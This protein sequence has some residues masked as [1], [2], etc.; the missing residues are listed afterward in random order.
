MVQAFVGTDLATVLELEEW[1]AKVGE[2]DEIAPFRLR[3]TTTF[4]A[5]AARGPWSTVTQTRSPR[6]AQTGRCGR[7]DGT[8]APKTG[9]SPSPKARARLPLTPSQGHPRE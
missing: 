2:R 4:A 9:T 1:Q 3:V 7:A 8:A 5:M 6:R